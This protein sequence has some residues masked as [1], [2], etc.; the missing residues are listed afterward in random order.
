[1]RTSLTAPDILSAPALRSRGLG[2]IACA[3]FGAFWAG[4]AV[5]TAAVSY[6]AAYFFVIALISTWLLIAAVRLLRRS[7]HMTALSDTVAPAQRRTRWLFFAIFA[8]EIIA[9]NVVANLLVSHHRISYLMP[10]IAV[11]VGLHFYPLAKLF[12]A[13]RYYATATVMTLAGIGAI[14][15]L[16][17]GLA[18]SPVDVTLDIICALALWLTGLLSWRSA[19]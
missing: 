7:R 8:A 19:R 13:T 2:M 16:N 11:I 10:A 18:V 17:S 6:A 12:R 9:L 14:L 15:A 5:A 3:C 1:M 4:T